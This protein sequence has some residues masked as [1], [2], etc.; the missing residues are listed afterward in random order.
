MN[1][2]SFRSFFDQ[3]MGKISKKALIVDTRLMVV[4]GYTMI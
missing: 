4:A 2:G 1:D 3:V